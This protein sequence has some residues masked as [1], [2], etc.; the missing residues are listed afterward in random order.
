M[1]HDTALIT[2]VAA[3]LGVSTDEVMMVG[4]DGIAVRSFPIRFA[5]GPDRIEEPVQ[6]RAYPAWE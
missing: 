4:D 5:V 1:P 6:G 3:G 2:T